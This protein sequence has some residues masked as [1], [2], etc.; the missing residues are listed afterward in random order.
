MTNLLDYLG[1]LHP[2]VLHLPIGIYV[3]AFVLQYLKPKRIQIDQ[4]IL[5]ILLNAGLIAACL[6]WLFGWLLSRSGDYGENI[7]FW[8]Q[9]TSLAFVLSAFMVS[10][11]HSIKAKY[12]WASQLY[13]TSFFL[14][15]FLI[16]IS[17]HFGGEITHGE[18]FL[19]GEVKKKTFSVRS[20][21]PDPVPDSQKIELPSIQP[22]DSSLLA[23]ARKAGFT[24]R[25]VSINSG[26]LEV[27]ALNMTDLKN[28]RINLLKPFAANILWISL[29]GH[30][31]TDV[32]L[33]VIASMKNVR[34]VDL[35][36]TSATDQFLTTIKSLSQLEYL[37]LV[38]TNI[39]GNGLGQLVS[40]KSLKRVYC[41]KTKILKSDIDNIRSQR[42]DLSI[43]ID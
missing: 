22:A 28:D 14:S 29:A 25:P 7:I 3:L 12:S 32:E 13:H 18:D 17:G 6:T 33:A 41:W 31:I 26:F 30:A 43:Y 11:M 8:H 20:I 37:N 9:W 40:I 34:R 42:P 16:T 19:L 27:N 2:L 35:R 10:L 39:T 4:R 1:R 15:L 21:Q 23:A 5:S 38:G 36:N 24:I